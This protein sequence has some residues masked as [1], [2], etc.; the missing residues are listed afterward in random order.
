[1][2]PHG[3]CILFTVE[4]G[5]NMKTKP[6][7]DLAYSFTSSIHLHTILKL[8]HKLINVRILLIGKPYIKGIQY[9]IEYGV[10]SFDVNIPIRYQVHGLRNINIVI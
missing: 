6:N 3:D 5:V 1:M 10:P 9:I 2:R 8:K 4:I 7:L